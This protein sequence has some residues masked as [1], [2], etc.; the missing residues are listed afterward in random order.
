MSEHYYSPKPL[1]AQRRRHIEVPIRGNRLKFIT[2]SG[3]FSKSKIDYGS[4]LLM[5]YMDVPEDA[6]VLDVG[7]GYGPIGLCAAK[8]AVNGFVTMIDINE[9]AVQL[10]KENAELNELMNTTVIQ[11]DLFENIPPQDFTRILTNPPIR[12][13]KDAVYTIFE[14][15][16]M[17]LAVR[18]ELW[19]VIQKKQGAPSALAKLQSIFEEVHEVC[20]DKGFRIFRA[21]KLEN[22][23]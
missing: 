17:R 11:S 12:A 4:M 13:G 14:E 5:K 1:S 20:K 23:I 22:I 9:R 6:L 18:G 10:A 19:V 8:L 15:S 21:V 2:D 3:V 16:Y 7:C